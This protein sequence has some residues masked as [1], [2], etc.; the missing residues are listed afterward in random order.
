MKNI[1]QYLSFY[2]EVSGLVFPQE[3]PEEYYSL[4]KFYVY[5][6][7]RGDLAHRY[8]FDAED[9]GKDV[10]LLLERQESSQGSNIYVVRTN[11]YGIFPF[12]IEPTRHRYVGRLKKLK[13]VQLFRVIP[14]NLAKL[15]EAC[16]S[17]RFFFCGANDL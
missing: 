4:G 10:R 7:S 2:P 11:K 6:T 3:L 5:A 8:H 12:V 9:E 1:V 13:N 14:L 15:E 17:H 16:L